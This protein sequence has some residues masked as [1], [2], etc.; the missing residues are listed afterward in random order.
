MILLRSVSYS[1]RNDALPETGSSFSE[2]RS[3]N[4]AVSHSSCCFCT[5]S[6]QD[7][8]RS[9]SFLVSSKEPGLKKLLHSEIVK[10]KCLRPIHFYG[11]ALG[12]PNIIGLISCHKVEIAK[13]VG[14]FLLVVLL[15]AFCFRSIMSNFGHH[16]AKRR[17]H[18]TVNESMTRDD[19]LKKWKSALCDTSEFEVI[20][21]ESSEMSVNP[22]ADQSGVHNEDIFKAYATLEPAYL[23]FLSECGMS[24]W[25]YWRGGLS[26]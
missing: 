23:K 26:E 25:G 9:K 6:C 12:S 2:R 21:D 17:K 13:Q 14:C 7:K 24:E 18:G 10:E 16:V 1:N 5:N 20:N 19:T 15:I 8:K 4:P 11:S 22:P 3:S